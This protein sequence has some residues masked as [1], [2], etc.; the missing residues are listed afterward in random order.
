VDRSQ[1]ESC[2]GTQCYLPHDTGRK[3]ARLNPS[4]AN[5]YWEICLLGRRMS[6]LSQ[7]GRVCIC[8]AMSLIEMSHQHRSTPARA[9]F[10]LEFNEN[11]N[12]PDDANV[13]GERFS[14]DLVGTGIQPSNDF[15]TPKRRSVQLGNLQYLSLVRD[16]PVRHVTCIVRSSVCL[17]VCL[18][19]VSGSKTETHKKQNRFCHGNECIIYIKF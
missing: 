10:A 12:E 6:R 7:R 8:S 14:S 9:T 5:W 18:A 2:M 4:R 17:S 15:I 3:K 11:H 13:S 19:K 16:R 1:S